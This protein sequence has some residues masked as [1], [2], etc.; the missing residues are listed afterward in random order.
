[1]KA[2]IAWIACLS[3]LVLAPLAGA[4]AEDSKTPAPKAA[5]AKPSSAQG[6]PVYSLPSVGKPRKRVGGGRRGT[7][8][9]V[10]DVFVLVPD[11]VGLTVSDQPA[12]YWYLADHARGDLSF[13]LTLIDDE[14]IDPLVDTSLTAP[15]KPGL[16]KVDLAAY[17]VRLKP[18]LEYQWSVAL[19]VDPKERSKDVV[20]VGWIEVVPA[21]E[22]LAKRLEQA[23]SN[24]A[25]NVYGEAGLWYDMLDTVCED[26]DE[27][28]GD[29]SSVLN[30]VG[31][32]DVASAP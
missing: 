1:M 6:G 29:F 19:V 10:P 5:S 31:L 26:L 12:L 9:D 21:P 23:G 2:I 20:S 18:G 3:L 17:G 22:D 13:E 15:V 25:S 8:G 28:P 11:H 27:N 4:D 7:E 16:Q 14:S 30:Q 32:P 24:G